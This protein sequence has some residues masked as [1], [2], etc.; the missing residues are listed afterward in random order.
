M[1]FDVYAITAATVQ[2][3]V[4]AGHQLRRCSRHLRQSVARFD[5]EEQELRCKIL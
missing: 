3:V 4:D 2:F 5:R 1:P